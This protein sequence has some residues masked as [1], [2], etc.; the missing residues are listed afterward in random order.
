[1]LEFRLKSL[2][3]FKKMPMQEW[4]PDL[5]EIDFDD[6]TYF[7]KA[8][9]RPARDWED[10]PEKIK[11]TFERIGIPEAER[12]YLAGASAQ[13]ESEVVYH[14]MKE[15]YDKLGIILQIRTQLLKSTQNSSRSTSQ[16]WFHQQTINLR[17]LTLPSG[18]VVPLF[19]YL[20]A[21]RWIFR[22]KPTS[23]LTMKQLPSLNVPLSSLM[24]VP[25]F[26]M[27]KAVRHQPILQPVF[28]QP[29][30][31]SLHLK[32]LICVIQPFKTGQIASIIW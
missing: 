12:A 10:V 9:D 30:L 6:L 18:Q 3:T 7:Q 5:S 32:E 26:T 13:Y 11:E 25:A 29:S 31:K 28:M 24:K 1:M 20:K 23:V 27:W 14:N 21:S 17:P 16:N 4:G 15:E 2:E 22:F 8:S 19:M